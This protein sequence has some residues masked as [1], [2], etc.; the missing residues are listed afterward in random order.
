[1]RDVDSGYENR[2][3]YFVHNFETNNMK[4]T[5]QILKNDRIV[6]RVCNKNTR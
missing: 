4:Q 5:Y 1:M 6:V 2:V 3:K